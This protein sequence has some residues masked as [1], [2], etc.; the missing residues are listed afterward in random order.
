MSETAR[1][2]AQEL[3]Q[4]LDHLVLGK[5]VQAQ[6]ILAV[7]LAQGHVLLNDVPGVA[8]T[9]LA[10][11][12]ASL[13]SL[14]VARV[15]GTP[16]LLPQ[17]ITGGAIYDLKT[18]E[19]V[20]RPGPVFHHILVMDEIN[21]A[22]PRTQAAL[23]ECME[24]RQVTQDGITHALP[25]PFL[26]MATQ[27]PVEMDGTFPLPE[28]E[29][30]RFLVSL[31]LGYP[32]EDDEK[33][34]VEEFSVEDPLSKATPIVNAD[35]ILRM[36]D[37][38]RTVLINPPTLDYLVKLLRATRTHPLVDLGASPRTTIRFA[39]LL[40]AHAWLQGRDYATPDDIKYLA[41]HVLAH[42]LQ[43]SSAATVS[44]VTGKE[45]VQQIL[46]DLTVPV[47]DVQ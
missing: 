43:P 37:E 35:Q 33:R 7:W 38:V 23:L 10:R 34:L 17:D 27:N 11:A 30:D 4:Q 44:R 25:N 12:L 1:G 42:R 47:E 14:T 22:T 36:S 26:V 18:S 28:A 2:K 3:L 9:R 8:K 13:S 31:S 41:P 5:R 21:R 45:L 20:F 29:L 32:D 40:R 39:Q 19:L 16:D 46:T 15:Q 24:E 6:L